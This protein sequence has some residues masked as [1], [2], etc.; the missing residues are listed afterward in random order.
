MQCDC[1]RFVFPTKKSKYFIFQKT[2]EKFRFI[3]NID[4]F[5]VQLIV[6]TYRLIN[7]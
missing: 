4:T 1:S 2:I 5:Q 7:S 6:Q 3:I